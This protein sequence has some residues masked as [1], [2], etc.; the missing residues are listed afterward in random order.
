[1]LRKSTHKIILA[2]IFVLLTGACQQAKQSTNTVSDLSTM[3]TTSS[4]PVTEVKEAP[5]NTE[6]P[7]TGGEGQFQGTYVLEIVPEE[8]EARYIVE[9]EFFGRGFATAIGVTNV[10]EGEITIN[11]DGAPVVE[12]GEIRVDLRTLTSDETRRDNAIRQRWLASNSFPLAV[13]V[14]TALEAFP[15]DFG[16]NEGEEVSFKLIGEMTIHDVTQTLSL[17]VLAVGSGDFLRGQ[18]TTEFLMTDFG[19]D[20]PSII[21]VLAAEDEVK[22]ELDF[23]LRNRS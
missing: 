13:F 16:F 23:T 18:A 6:E 8:T 2:L 22:V 1:M 12:G 10:V 3:A 17:N 5:L 14:P 9:E 7:S 15:G 21:N 11:I 4:T 20:P 19:F